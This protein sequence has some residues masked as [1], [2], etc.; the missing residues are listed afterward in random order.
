MKVQ[1]WDYVQC[2]LN[3]R[4]LT[5]LQTMAY[6]RGSKVP[7][8]PQGPVMGHESL[9][10]KNEQMESDLKDNISKVKTI[11]I[12]IQQELKDQK[13]LF[14]DMD[15]RLSS[16]SLMITNTIG[17]VGKLLKSDSNYHIHYLVLFCL[18]VFLVLSFYVR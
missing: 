8:Y 15:N 11:A 7:R 14:D 9:E 10:D 16:T 18:F 12:N 4:L 3:N 13:P 2:S 17:K 6:S 1:T 5:C